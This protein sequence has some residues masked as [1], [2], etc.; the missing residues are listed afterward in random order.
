I[1]LSLSLSLPRT[2]SRHC[3]PERKN[4][5]RHHFRPPQPSRPVPFELSPL[6]RYFPT[7]FSPHRSR[8]S[9]ARRISRISIRRSFDYRTDYRIL[10]VLRSHIRSRRDPLRVKLCGTT[11]EWT[12]LSKFQHN[13]IHGKYGILLYLFIE[14][15]IYIR[16]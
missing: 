5:R 12:F 10:C 4:P 15:G 7:G 1:S 13:F 9:R 6:P 3:S 14:Y 16:M 11:C 8:L 2:P